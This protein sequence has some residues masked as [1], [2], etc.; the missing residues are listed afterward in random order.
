M[1]SST[2]GKRLSQQADM[3]V[4]GDSPGAPAEP[5]DPVESS[6]AALPVGDSTPASSVSASAAGPTLSQAPVG[7]PS[8][9]ASVPAAEPR[10][11]SVPDGEQEDEDKEGGLRSVPGP[12]VKTQKSNPVPDGKQYRSGDS[13]VNV[14]SPDRSGDRRQGYD[15]QDDEQETDVSP[16]R[17]AGSVPTGGSIPDDNCLMGNRINTGLGRM[18]ARRPRVPKV[19]DV[20]RRAAEVIN[21]SFD[22]E[23]QR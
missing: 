9:S 19:L 22:T 12:G 4:G 14:S 10:S 1:Q 5:P 3:T 7:S 11:S 23:P 8:D 17:D 13:D 15:D 18:L 20:H 2:S 16:H 6:P 21:D